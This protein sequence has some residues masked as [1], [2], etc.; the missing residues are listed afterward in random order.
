MRDPRESQKKFVSEGW[1][2]EKSIADIVASHARDTPDKTAFIS[3][4]EKMS[5]FEYERY[6]SD[7]S[8]MIMKSGLHAGDKVAIMLPDGPSVHA[9][10]VGTEKSGVVAV[11]IGPRAGEAEVEHILRRTGARSVI[12]HPI[13]D[14]RPAHELVEGLRRR[15]VEVERHFELPT[16]H[17]SDDSILLNGV[18]VTK[19]DPQLVENLISQRRLGPNDLWMLNSTSG[20]TGLPKCVTQFQNRW[21]AYHR[22]VCESAV[23]DT[24]DIFMSVVPAQFGFGLWTSHFTPTILGI[25]CVVLPKFNAERALASI[26]EFKVSLLAAVSTQFIM[27]LNTPDIEKFDLSSLE[28]MWTGGEAVPYERAAEFEDRTGARV[29]QFFGSNE[30]GALSATTIYDSREKRLTTCGKPLEIMQVRLFDS[31]DGSDIT[32][33]SGPGVP[34]CKGPVTCFGY[35]GD[36]AANDDLYTSDG[37]MLMGDVV[38]IESDGYLRLVGR[39]SDFIIRGGKN[40]SA[41]VVE[42]Q[43]GTCAGVAIVAAVAVPDNVFGQKVAVYVELLDGHAL[44]LDFLNKHLATQGYSKETFP[45]YL[46]II[47]EMPMASG[48]KVAK[49]AIRSDVENRVTEGLFAQDFR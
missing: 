15:G 25:P 9:A 19:D 38:T 41:K 35:F 22:L 21:F 37:W 4:S 42:E 31:D 40:I 5:W 10:L 8:G 6:S 12:T 28:V 17:K 48:G 32:H 7:I 18:E 29:L 27:M 49:S 39:K 34:G 11:G 24:E 43:V 30:T 47:D 26:Q 16:S 13:I 14:E 45:E 44:T 36:D 46:V 23:V 3:G 2:S 1:W 33:S 20:T